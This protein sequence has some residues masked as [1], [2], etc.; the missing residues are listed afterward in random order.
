M[1]LPSFQFMWHPMGGSNIPLAIAIK[2]PSVGVRSAYKRGD[3]VKKIWSRLLLITLATTFFGFEA[4]I[5]RAG[6]LRIP[7]PR[8]SSATPVQNLNRRGV[9]E[10]QKQHYDKA[11]DLFYQA[12][13]LDPDDPFTLNNLGYISELQGDVDRATHF[14]AL[15]IRQDS[16]AVVALASSPHVEGHTFRNVTGGISNPAMQVNRGNVEAIRMF[17][18]RRAVEAETV[19]QRTL[20][21]DQNNPFT[22]NNMGVAKEAEGD[23][24]GALKYYSAAANSPSAASAAVTSE[25][26]SRGRPVTQIAADNVK[27]VKAR[28]HKSETPETRV[29]LLNLRGVAAINR[30]DPRQ[31]ALDF[32][33]AYKVDPGNAFTLNNLGYVA[34]MGGDLET[35]QSFYQSAR[36]A[37]KANA[38]VGLATRRSAEGMKLLRVAEDSD[39]QVDTQIERR[40]QERRRESRPIILKRRDGQPVEPGPQSV[41]RPPASQ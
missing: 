32:L 7:L 28:M 41:P 31:G 15:S 36:E 30:N 14:Y 12:Y 5:A 10:V 23:F 37:E 6:D 20:Q 21:L 19:L 38:R 8:R 2:N 11:R 16:N 9:E 25:S 13:L 39:R 3:E 34:E 22:L 4:T 27:R 1:Q 35:A 33:Q 18:Q 29:A 26:D 24:E 17:S 40:Q